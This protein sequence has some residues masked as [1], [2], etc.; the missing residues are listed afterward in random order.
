MNKSSAKRWFYIDAYR[1][2]VAKSILE[3]LCGENYFPSGPGLGEKKLRR[4]KD[5]N[6]STQECPTWYKN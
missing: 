1:A 4:P 5:Y 2:G 3:L 6:E